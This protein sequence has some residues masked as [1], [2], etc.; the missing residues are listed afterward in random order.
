M[1]VCCVLQAA[2][3]AERTRA[4]GLQSDTAALSAKLGSAE[5]QV[6]SLTEEV[7]EWRK[8]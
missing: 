1:L 8:R 6:K 2:L 3:A 4:A 7:T 5:S